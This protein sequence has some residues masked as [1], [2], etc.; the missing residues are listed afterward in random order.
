MRR[1]VTRTDEMVL[2]LDATLGDLL[3]DRAGPRARDAGRMVVVM[4]TCLLDTI[5]YFGWG[6]RD[7]MR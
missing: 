6:M 4:E 5:G 7:R 1:P 2:E 3:Q